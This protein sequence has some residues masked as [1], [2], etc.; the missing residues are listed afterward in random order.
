MFIIIIIILFRYYNFELIMV[1]YLYYLNLKDVCPR[2]WPKV[3]HPSYK[4]I[5]HPH[6]LKIST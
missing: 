1:I 5:H 3:V 2:Y 6:C 4:L